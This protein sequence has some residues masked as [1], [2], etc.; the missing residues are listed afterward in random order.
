MNLE[1]AADDPRVIIPLAMAIETVITAGIGG[2]GARAL[3]GRFW[4]GCL[5]GFAYGV[6]NALWKRD[7]FR[8]AFDRDQAKRKQDDRVREWARS[9]FFNGAR[10]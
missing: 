1:S 3:G 9:N 7:A 2:I 10:P 6:A 4:S 8:E 5:G